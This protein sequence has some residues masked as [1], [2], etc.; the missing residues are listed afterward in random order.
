MEIITKQEA[1]DQHLKSYYTG[2][3]CANGHLS[4]LKMVLPSGGQNWLR[5]KISESVPSLRG[6]CTHT[7]EP[8]ITF[9]ALE[10]AILPSLC[11]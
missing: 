7:T 3:P 4:K 10:A 9:H 8:A 2:K 5:L 6:H 1:L 11:I